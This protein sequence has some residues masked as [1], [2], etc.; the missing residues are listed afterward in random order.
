MLEKVETIQVNL[1]ADMEIKNEAMEWT[2]STDVP[3]GVYRSGDQLLV[4]LVSL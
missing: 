2:R 3:A 4:I 1:H